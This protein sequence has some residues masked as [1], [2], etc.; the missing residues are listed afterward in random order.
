MVKHDSSKEI[1]F[2]A[3]FYYLDKPIAILLLLKVIVKHNVV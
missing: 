1:I 2:F 3:I